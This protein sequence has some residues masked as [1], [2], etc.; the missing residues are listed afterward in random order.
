[1]LL[2][3]EIL[4]ASGNQ[5]QVGYACTG[6]NNRE[7]A[8]KFEGSGS[9]KDSSEDKTPNFTNLRNNQMERS[10]PCHEDAASYSF[11]PSK[12]KIKLSNS[13]GTIMRSRPNKKLTERNVSETSSFIKKMPNETE[14]TQYLVSEKAESTGT[15][16]LK[17]P[18]IADQ[19]PVKIESPYLGKRI[20]S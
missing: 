12:K 20:V 14:D 13:N 3:Q 7:V 10:S 19:P 8:L 4:I 1:M 5:E 17:K 6:A 16:R 15:R 11:P 18:V 9:A 2:V